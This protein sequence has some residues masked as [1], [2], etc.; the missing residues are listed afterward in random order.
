[1][2]TKSRKSMMDRFLTDELPETTPAP[3][4]EKTPK[5]K[6]LMSG[7]DVLNKAMGALNTEGGLMMLDINSI[8]IDEHK[9]R[10]LS[11][12]E[13]ERLKRSI[14]EDGLFNPIT[15][16]KTER[17]DCEFVVVS[18]HN[19][20]R[21]LKELGLKEVPAN[22]VNLKDDG[23]KAA[24]VSNLLQPELGVAE[25]YEG[26]KILQRSDDTEK[27][28]RMLAK[29]TGFSPAYISQVLSMESLPKRLIS[30]MK[31]SRVKIGSNVLKKFIN[32]F[33]D[34][35]ES[36]IDKLAKEAISRIQKN[37]LLHSTHSPTLVDAE[38]L[39]ARDG[40]DKTSH[41]W[42]VCFSNFIKEMQNKA[43]KDKPRTSL[44]LRHWEL[45]KANRRKNVV[46]LTFTDEEH[47]QHFMQLYDLYT[48][49]SK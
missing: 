34:K 42:Q 36:Q 28:I 23:S 19:R 12:A 18:G 20:L 8:G 15:V 26:L 14:Q 29:E 24:F 43:P 49:R 25:I 48:T 4:P 37:A 41:A 45:E 30:E 2:N 9:M 21:A 5:S 32:L 33:V 1:M 47:A 3:T 35:S 39:S 38:T 44:D 40:E 46:T 17:K 27:S 13:F 10:A 11:S 6:P 7:M 31:S 22:A 16:N